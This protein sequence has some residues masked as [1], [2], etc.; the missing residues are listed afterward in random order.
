MS[1]STFADVRFAGAIRGGSP[2]AFYHNPATQ[3]WV[4]VGPNP[5]SQDFGCGGDKA[6]MQTF[7]QMFPERDHALEAYVHA[8]H[9]YNPDDEFDAGDAQHEMRGAVVEV[10]QESLEL[11]DDGYVIFPERMLSAVGAAHGVERRV[12][13]AANMLFGSSRDVTQASDGVHSFES[14]PTY[15]RGDNDV[16]DSSGSSTI[17]D[18][19]IP[20][21]SGGSYV[22]RTLFGQRDVDVLRRYRGLDHVRISGPPGSGKTTLPRAAFGDDVVYVQGHPDMTVSSLIG[23][24]L[25]APPGSPT[26]WVWADGPL[27]RAARDGLVFVQDEANRLAEEVH[28]AFLSATD[29]QRTII[30]SDRPDLPP[31]AVADGF[32]LILAYNDADHG[33]RPLPAALLRRC[34]VHIEIET[35]YR[36]ADD[37]VDPRLIR[38][39]ENLAAHQ[40][41][42]KPQMADL[43]AAQRSLNVFGVEAAAS[44]MIS[45]CPDKSRREEIAGIVESVFG[46]QLTRVNHLGGAY[47]PGEA[48]T[49]VGEV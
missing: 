29:D 34:P 8:G 47:H 33:T 16:P 25:P 48:P 27:L 10:F 42:W 18:N 45:A 1:T 26:P 43:L 3:R 19:A 14:E 7:V 12:R 49:A 9:H 13:A 22:P 31:V 17:T 5:D 24:Y 23:Q 2:R 32:M 37:S 28:A 21:P 15:H 44:I 35:D 46:R 11:D 20:L 6:A 41:Q 40:G 38:V 4:V 39:A 36:L 30:I